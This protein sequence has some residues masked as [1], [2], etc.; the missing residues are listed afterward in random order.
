M[1]VSGAWRIG[2]APTAGGGEAVSS[3]G[4]KWRRAGLD[5]REVL[6]LACEMGSVKLPAVT[7]YRK[8]RG[9]S[10]RSWGGRVHFSLPLDVDT[11]TVRM[12]VAHEVAHEGLPLHVKH[13][14][15]WRSFYVWLVETTWGVKVQAE[16][17]SYFDLDRRVAAALK[18]E[19]L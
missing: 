1:D 5:V 17:G 14:P 10:G 6:A 11:A 18:V 3:P 15:D 9:Y 13:G 19:G 16:G 12:L 7:I 8:S 4:W 2:E